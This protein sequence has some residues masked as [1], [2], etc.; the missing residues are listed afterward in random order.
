MEV[1]INW[2]LDLELSVTQVQKQAES[3]VWA[4]SCWRILWCLH[5]SLHWPVHT[6]ELLGLLTDEWLRPG[7]VQTLHKLQQ[8]CEPK[9]IPVSLLNS[10]YLFKFYKKIIFKIQDDSLKIVKWLKLGYW[11]PL[12]KVV[13]CL[14]Q[15]KIS[16][17]NCMK[18][19]S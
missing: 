8:H 17:R 12:N 1:E 16:S 7:W 10:Y 9:K 13:G 2:R 18:Y 15:S 11:K 6:P 5:W 4:E 3:C 19:F 14:R